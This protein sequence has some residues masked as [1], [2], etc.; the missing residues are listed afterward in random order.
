MGPDSTRREFVYLV[1]SAV[2]GWYKIGRSKSPRMRRY[3][4]DSVLPFEIELIAVWETTWSVG[5]EK[6]MHH[7]CMDRRIR[8]EWFQFTS[9]QLTAF[10]ECQDYEG[11]QAVRL[12][13]SASFASAPA[14][15][16]GRQTYWQRMQQQLGKCR[17]CGKAKEPERNHLALCLQCSRKAAAVTKQSRRKRLK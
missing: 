8:G 10:L 5:L 7:L 6:E 14:K 17:Q 2:H 15:K 16:P 12:D 1:G 11:V 9:E 4:I 13:T 3:V